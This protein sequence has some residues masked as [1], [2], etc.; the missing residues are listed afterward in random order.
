MTLLFSLMGCVISKPEDPLYRLQDAYNKRD[1]SAM[2]ECFDPDAQR[3][4]KG[5]ASLL[6]GAFG[7]NTSAL[8]DMMPFLSK[9][10]GD[11][12]ALDESFDYGTV[13]FTDIRTQQS[14]DSAT[15]TYTATIAYPN[16]TTESFQQTAEV[17]KVDGKWYLAA[18]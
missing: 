8:M 14:G 11:S 1:F 3:F 4:M 5:A 12:G 13:K 2:I 15:L 16:G 6:G 17:V 7:I 10:L 9:S 18:Y